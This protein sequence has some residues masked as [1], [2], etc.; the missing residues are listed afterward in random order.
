MGQ[1]GRLLTFPTM[2]RVPPAPPPAPPH[3]RA[4]SSEGGPSLG[5][6]PGSRVGACSGL[7]WLLVGFQNPGPEAEVPPAS[8]PQGKGGAGRRPSAGVQPPAGLSSH[9]LPPRAR[10][11]ATK[12]VVPSRVMTWS[13]GHKEAAHQRRGHGDKRWEAG[14]RSQAPGSPRPLLPPPRW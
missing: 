1:G 13:S 5:G 12:A 14:A 7:G 6:G 8:P 2:L 10:A 3:L 9:S 4:G 11:L